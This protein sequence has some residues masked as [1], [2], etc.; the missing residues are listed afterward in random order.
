VEEERVDEG[1]L[2]A[3]VICAAGSGVDH[4]SGGFVDHGEVLVF[5][6]DVKGD[7][8]GDGMEWFGLGRAFDLDGFAAVEFLLGLGCVAVDADLTGFDEELDAGSGDIGECLSEVLIEAKTGGGRVGGEGAD[9]VFAVVFEIE[10][11]NGRRRRLFDTTGGAVFGFY[12]AAALALG[13]HVLRRH[14]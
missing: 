2:V 7:V 1:T 8:F 5:V 4:H 14:G 3:G 9:A 6:E 12:G 10:D 13:E 11:G